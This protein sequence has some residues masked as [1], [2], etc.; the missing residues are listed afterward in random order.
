M[1]WLNKNLLGNSYVFAVLSI[2]LVMYGPRLHMR[3]PKSVRVLFSNPIFRSLI[4]FIV[5][6]M[7]NHD[8]T[9]AIMIVVVF[10]IVMYT[11][12]VTS[13]LEGFYEE[14]MVETEESFQNYGPPV[15]QCSNYK[16]SDLPQPTYPLN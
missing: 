1:K 7:S 15:S 10:L 5:V 9:S 12:Q 4:L 2:F 6:F 11:V 13:V 14:E 16:D 3:L 8:M